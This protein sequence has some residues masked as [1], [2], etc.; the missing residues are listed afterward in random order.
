MTAYMAIHR[1][2]P[3]ACAKA[4]VPIL[5]SW[6]ISRTLCSPWSVNQWATDISR[7]SSRHHYKYPEETELINNTPRW[8]LPLLIGLVPHA[9]EYLEQVLKKETT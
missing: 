9:S 2:H 1:G 5:Q 7:C 8:K 3:E 6:A 4:K